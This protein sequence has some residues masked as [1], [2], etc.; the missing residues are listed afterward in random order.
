MEEAL[1]PRFRFRSA[2]SSRGTYSHIHLYAPAFIPLADTHGNVARE[3]MFVRVRVCTCETHTTEE[4]DGIS[5]GYE[6]GS[7]V[8]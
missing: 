5:R 1:Q 4:R 3:P 2:A 8:P 7:A 6:R